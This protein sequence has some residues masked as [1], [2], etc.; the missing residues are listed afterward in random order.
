L[1]KNPEKMRESANG[2]DFPLP[3]SAPVAWDAD[4][5]RIGHD[6]PD[7]FLATNRSG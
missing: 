5:R 1:A 3:I 2:P 7:V 4:Q 6:F